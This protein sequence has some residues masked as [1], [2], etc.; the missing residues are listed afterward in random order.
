[1]AGSFVARNKYF[2]TRSYT[3][4]SGIKNKIKLYRKPC[5]LIDQ[6]FFPGTQNGVKRHIAWLRPAGV[7]HGAIPEDLNEDEHPIESDIP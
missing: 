1:M 6:R 7:S 2:V 3:K 4:K 5:S